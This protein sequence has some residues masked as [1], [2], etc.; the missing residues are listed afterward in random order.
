MA[1]AWVEGRDSGALARST[2]STFPDGP[3]RA[4]GSPRELPSGHGCLA[5]ATGGYDASGAD[6]RRAAE[7]LAALN[8][9]ASLRSLGTRNAI[10]VDDRIRSATEQ[11]GIEIYSRSTRS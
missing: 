1:T 9:R 4:C 6:P 11:H 2:Y 3:R 8:K 10:L 7:V 5:R